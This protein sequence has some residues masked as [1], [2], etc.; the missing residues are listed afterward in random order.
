[1]SARVMQRA[2]DDRPGPETID[3]K[4]RALVVDTVKKTIA[5][6]AAERPA[7]KL[8]TIP[9]V[10]AL[11]KVDKSTVYSWIR[12]RRLNVINLGGAGGASYRVH[13]AELDRFLAACPPP[14]AED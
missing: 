9:E 2:A 6:T 3:E 5:E 10:A 13:Q 8:L 12:E 11:V 14:G 1:M 4:I 7:K